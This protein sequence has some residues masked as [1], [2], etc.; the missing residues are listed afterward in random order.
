MDVSTLKIIR[1]LAR[2][3]L[4]AVVFRGILNGWMVNRPLRIFRGVGKASWLL[5]LILFSI[6]DGKNELVRIW[7]RNRP[8]RRFIVE[9]QRLVVCIDSRR[10]MVHIDRTEQ[11]KCNH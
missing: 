10:L 11:L 6:T 3:V 4:L 8:L 5:L 7:L 1:L 9:P 2:I